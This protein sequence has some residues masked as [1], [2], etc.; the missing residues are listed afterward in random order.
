MCKKVDA[1]RERVKSG[2]ENVSVYQNRPITIIKLVSNVDGVKYSAVEYAKV[3]WPDW[4]N[5]QR[6]VDVAVGKAT[7]RIAE[8]IVGGEVISEEFQAFDDIQGARAGV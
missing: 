6:G 7:K 3:N 5:R 2:V 8:G 1:A 4:W